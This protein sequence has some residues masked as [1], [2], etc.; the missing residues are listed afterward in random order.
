MSAVEKRRSILGLSLRAKVLLGMFAA[1]V[2]FASAPPTASAVGADAGPVA[3]AVAPAASVATA[4]AAEEAAAEEAGAL[5]EEHEEDHLTPSTFFL[6]LISILIFAKVFGELA[7]RIGQ[8]SVLGEL[9][10][11]LVLGSSV[12]GIVPAAGIGAE[13]IH[14]LAEVGVAIL[15][16]EIGL[17]TDLKEMFRVGGSSASVALVGVALP[18]L[19]GYLYWLLADPNIG[20][21]PEGI[22]H[23]MVSVFVGATLTAT[24]VGITARVLTD[25][26][27]MHRAESRII[28]GA[29]VIDDVLGLV[30]LAVV[31]GLASG[32]ALSFIGIAQ[33]FAIAVGFLVAAVIIGNL[34][35][36]K[37]FT[38]VDQMRVRGILLVSAFCFALL[39]A[40]LADKAGSALIIG[41]FAAGIVL[42][43]T[44]QFDLIVER[45]EPVADIFT[46]IFFVSVGAAV[47]VN[48]FLPWSDEYNQSVIVV[49]AILVVVAFIG[50]LVAGYVVG[51]GKEKLNHAAIGVGMVPRGEVGLI[52]ADIGRRAGILSPETFSAILI[53]V[54]VTTFIAPPLLKVVFKP[55]DGDRGAPQPASPH[56]G[57]HF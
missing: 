3:T 46:P 21:H 36:P 37:L 14:L 33:T 10:A 53:M 57:G 25:L 55:K 43:S 6:I 35:A 2:W 17:E 22:S 54:I 28:I 12:L 50:K 31:S 9:I 39:F 47:N 40:A 13:V 49:G 34:V 32:A 41:S 11:G 29:A 8:P 24:S 15:L 4:T 19:L 26:K 48:L 20:A 38:F 16:F 56:G 42:S 44:N 51:W 1:V 45:V 5:E 27:L 7:E 30:I 18:F 52:F 23:G